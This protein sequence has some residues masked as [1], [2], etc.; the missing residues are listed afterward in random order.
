MS[1]GRKR[2][3]KI[4]N[5]HLCGFFVQSDGLREVEEARTAMLAF[6]RDVDS[7]QAIRRRP[8]SLKP[9]KSTDIT[10][11]INLVELGK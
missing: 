4:R 7:P 3:R 10:P 11:C 5:L 1:E 8:S 2:I 6:S 9:Q